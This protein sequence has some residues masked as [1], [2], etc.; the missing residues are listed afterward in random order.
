MYPTIF[1]VHPARGPVAVCRLSSGAWF[2]TACLICMTSAEGLYLLL[3]KSLSIQS[4]SGRKLR[5]FDMCIP[6]SWLSQRKRLIPI[7]TKCLSRFGIT[8]GVV[9]L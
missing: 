2:D 8:F 5:E 4:R 1:D 9:L 3:S 7:D 6:K